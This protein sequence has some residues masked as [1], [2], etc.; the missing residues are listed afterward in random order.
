M[1][2]PRRCANLLRTRKQLVRE[3]I[4][5]AGQFGGIGL[6]GNQGLYHSSAPFA[7][8]VGKHRVQFYVGV[9]E[10]LLHTQHVAQGV[11]GETA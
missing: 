7:H 11:S 10:C 9:L 2:E 4:G 5:K 8:D 3:P 1:P 6:A